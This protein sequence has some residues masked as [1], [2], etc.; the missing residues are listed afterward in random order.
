MPH[1]R[2]DLYAKVLEAAGLPDQPPP[3]EPGAAPEP[4]KPAAALPGSWDEINVGHL[5]IALEDVDCCWWAAIVISIDGDMLKL[6]WR[7]FPKYKPFVR[8]RAAVALL[9]PA[10]S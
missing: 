10:A 8:H 6:R 4:E 9:K 2:R 3:N 1:V 7:D 5:V